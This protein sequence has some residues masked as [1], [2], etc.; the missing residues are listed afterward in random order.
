MKLT[1][2]LYTPAP[3]IIVLEESRYA[4]EDRDR[5]RYPVLVAIFWF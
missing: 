5:L 4:H 2:A 1:I 3:L